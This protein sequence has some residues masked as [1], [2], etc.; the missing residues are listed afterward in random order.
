MPSFKSRMV[1]MLLKHGHLLSRRPRI[2]TFDRQPATLEFFRQQAIDSAERLGKLPDTVDVTPVDLGGLSAEWI[3]PA[4][5]QPEQ[6]LLYFHGGGYVS[7]S[8]LTHRAH[9]AK[10]VL[11]S[12][13]RALL[14][15][16]RIAPEH[17][18]PAALEDALHAY[19]WLLD[20]GHD[21][22]RIAFV[23]DSAGGGL[24]LATLVAARGQGLPLPAAAVALSPWTDLQCTGDS[25]VTRAKV[26]PFTPAGAWTVFSA[27]YAGDHDPADPLISPLYAALD[28][29][30]PLLIYAGDADVLVDDSLRF[31]DKA[32]AAGVDVTLHIGAGLFHCYPVCAP[33]FPEATEAMAAICAFIRA[34]LS[35]PPAAALQAHV[36]APAISLPA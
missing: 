4:G 16:Y 33:L 27:Y 17:P 19:R 28:G 30:P 15:D 32:R 21:P 25:I 6:T 18:Y 2:T 10:F 1:V 35:R 34:Q 9:V 29:L 13:G 3:S 12:G 23:G 11:G 8:C 7:G 14:F 24:C 5:A 36:A 31:A 20:Q 26:D 22:A